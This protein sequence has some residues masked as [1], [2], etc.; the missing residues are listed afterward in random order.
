LVLNISDQFKTN[1][2]G[3][4]NIANFKLE[5]MSEFI[6][7]VT[8]DYERSIIGTFLSI[9]TILMKSRPMDEIHFSMTKFKNDM[10]YSLI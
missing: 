6:E 9:L 8:V 7:E 10:A 4:F 1:N 5:F 2:I 3:G